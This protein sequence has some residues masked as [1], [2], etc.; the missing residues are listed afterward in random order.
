MRSDRPRMPT[1]FRGPRGW[2]LSP[3]GAAVHPADRT[4]V[5]ADVHLGYE[6]ARGSRGDCLPPHTLAE[7]LAKLARL[8]GHGAISRLVIGGDLVESST[9]CRRSDDDVRALT[10]WLDARGV[11]TVVLAGNHDPRRVPPLP[12]TLEVGG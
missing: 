9:P 10:R 11:S 2:F 4:A 12:D 3:E 6:W 8:L 1:L 5:I 7:T